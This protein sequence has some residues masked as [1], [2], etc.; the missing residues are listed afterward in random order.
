MEFRDRI[1]KI[2]LVTLVFIL[3]FVAYKRTYHTPTPAAVT[4]VEQKSDGKSL[5]IKEDVE[6]IVREFILNN[7]AVLIESIERMQQRKMDEM[8]AQVNDLIKGKK[9]ELEND[10][11]SPVV[12]TGNISVVMFYDVNCTYCKK[13][14]AIVDQL[15]S[16]NKDVKI[17]YKPLPILGESSTYATKIE[18][19]VYKLFPAKFKAIHTALMSEK[20]GSRDDVVLILDKNSIPVATI[21]AEFDSADMK[22]Y[23]KNTAMLASELK[24][25]GVPH[26]IIGQTLYPGFI[27]LGRMQGI[28]D[29]IKSKP[30]TPEPTPAV[31]PGA[32]T[33]EPEAAPA[34][35][36]APS[37]P[38]VSAP[39]PITDKKAE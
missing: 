14:N 37:V 6:N 39:A 36:P 29:D 10:K 23:I 1:G 5:V 38:S 3:A 17:I 22:D 11:M 7:P 9:A 2:L 4:S 31:A 18:I 26:F 25:Q 27:E 19:A 35:V 32:T 20:I 16:A 12:G 8:N 13:A 33:P 21:E 30:Q 24:I 34:T 28:I 15:L